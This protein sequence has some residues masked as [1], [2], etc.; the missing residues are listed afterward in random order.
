[1]IFGLDNGVRNVHRK[2]P[3]FSLKK[4]NSSRRGQEPH[5]LVTCRSLEIEDHRSHRHAGRVIF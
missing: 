5:F 2:R 3:F 1:M 4:V